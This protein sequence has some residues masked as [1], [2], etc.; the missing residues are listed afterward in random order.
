MPT[1]TAPR[2]VPK[3]VASHRMPANFRHGR[4]ITTSFGHFSSTG[5]PLN[6][7][8]ASATA[9]PAASVTSG[10]RVSSPRARTMADRYMPAPGGEYH[11]RPRRP[12]PA[13]CRSASTAVNSGAPSA[14]SVS[15]ASFVESISLK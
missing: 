10:T 11:G 15:A 9:T 6:S 3:A 13:R 4:P 7:D 2:G 14:A 5:N 1:T 8:T 12:R